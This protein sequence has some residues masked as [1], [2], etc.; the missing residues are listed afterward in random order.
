M[1]GREDWGGGMRLLIGRIEW[2]MDGW[3]GLGNEF[4]LLRIYVMGCLVQIFMTNIR[5]TDCLV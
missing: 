1:R 3:M 2:W 4:Y 5:M